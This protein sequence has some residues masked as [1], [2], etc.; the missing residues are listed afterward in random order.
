M[1]TRGKE[2]LRRGVL[3]LAVLV[4][5][6]VAFPAIAGAALV[7][8]GAALTLGGSTDDRIHP[9]LTAPPAWNDKRVNVYTGTALDLNGWTSVA[10][11]NP[12]FDD[13][14]GQVQGEF[15]SQVWRK[16][17]HLLFAYMI[18]NTGTRGIYTGDMVSRESL[19]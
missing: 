18:E 3:V 6:S 2:Q 13:G 14:T 12:T 9:A 17:N 1:K 15:N 19:Y 4:A 7:S 11:Q 5:A 10:S 8:P 16:D